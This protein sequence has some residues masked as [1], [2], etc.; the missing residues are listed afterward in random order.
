MATTARKRGPAGDYHAVG[1]V[2]MCK[3]SN[4]GV[5]PGVSLAGLI[6]YNPAT[7][8][9]PLVVSTPGARASSREFGCPLFFGAR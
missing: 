7:Q 8:F 1:G 6:V 5:Y 2:S 9:I 3:S 4:T